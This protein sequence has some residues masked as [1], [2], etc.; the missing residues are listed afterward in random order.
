MTKPHAWMI[1]IDLLDLRNKLGKNI[2]VSRKSK[3]LNGYI[4]IYSINK[5]GKKH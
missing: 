2:M 1:L 4:Y 3:I 5:L